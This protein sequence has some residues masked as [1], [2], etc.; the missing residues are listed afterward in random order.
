VAERYETHYG[1]TLMVT[2]IAWI[3]RQFAKAVKDEASERQD[4]MHHHRNSAVSQSQ[5]NRD[6]N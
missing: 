3:K 5:L 2:F 1:K 6:R 4:R